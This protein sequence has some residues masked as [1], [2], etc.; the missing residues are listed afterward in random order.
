V[1]SCTRKCRVD[2][3][4]HFFTA[5]RLQVSHGALNVS[6]SKPHL[7]GSQIN[8]GPQVPRCKRRTEFV[9]S[10]IVR[11]K[12]RT[13]STRLQ[14]IKKI[15]LRFATSSWKYQIARLV[16]RQLPCLQALYQ[17]RWDGDFTFFVCVDSFGEV[18]TPSDLG[19]SVGI[20]SF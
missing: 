4:T 20:T 8:T 7:H 3:R 13:F 6:V 5:R 16:T 11:I 18:V 14:A 2:L 9:K 1:I 17:L 15:K 19:I 12:L 10:K